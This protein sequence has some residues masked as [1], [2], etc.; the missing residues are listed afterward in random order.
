MSTK[1]P[2]EVIANDIIDSDEEKAARIR[3]NA[4]K[5]MSHI[6][7]CGLGDIKLIEL[8]EERPV[9]T[10]ATFSMSIRTI[11][12]GIGY[13]SI[14]EYTRAEL[15]AFAFKI[16]A[17]VSNLAYKKLSE[18]V[19]RIQEHLLLASTSYLNLREARKV[20]SPVKFLFLTCFTND[21]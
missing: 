13:L 2:T 1:V 5:R 11:I 12:H 4:S 3:G 17:A 10:P 7:G 19:L 16:G 21:N 20:S 15:N 18:V 6:L 8:D 9:V 14:R